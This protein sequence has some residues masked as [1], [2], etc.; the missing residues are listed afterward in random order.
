MVLEIATNTGEIIGV[1]AQYLL[2]KIK[3]ANAIKEH[4]L[5]Q[6]LLIVQLCSVSICSTSVNSKSH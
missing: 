1:L 5:D 3:P 6:N 2:C 4:R